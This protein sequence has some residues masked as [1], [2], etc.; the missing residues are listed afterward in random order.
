MVIAGN[1]VKYTE[2]VQ[3]RAWHIVSIQYMSVL[4]L[5]MTLD[6][7]DYCRELASGQE[8]RM[9]IFQYNPCLNLSF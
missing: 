9:N 7:T 8:D 1:T 4:I 5:A 2:G 3:Y 6:I